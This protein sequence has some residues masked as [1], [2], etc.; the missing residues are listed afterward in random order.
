MSRAF[1]LSEGQL[2]CFAGL[3]E[4][5]HSAETVL[6]FTKEADAREEPTVVRA[7]EA[8]LRIYKNEYDKPKVSYWPVNSSCVIK[9]GD[10][11]ITDLEQMMESIDENELDKIPPTFAGSL[12]SLGDPFLTADEASSSSK[13][14]P[15]SA[16]K[17]DQ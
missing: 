17:D 16:D 11:R 8:P 12:S 3:K 5:G 10:P 6:P 2:Q 13:D 14:D 4:K 7:G 9:D 15:S 1:Q